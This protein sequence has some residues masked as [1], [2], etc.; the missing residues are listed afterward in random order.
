[1]E[2]FKVHPMLDA[3]SV[4]VMN[5]PL[6]QCRLMNVREYPWL[7]LIPRQPNLRDWIDLSFEDQIQLQREINQ[8]ANV[9]KGQFPCEKLNIAS[10][11]NK[12][13]QLHIHVIAR[14]SQDPAWPNPVW[15]TQ[16]TPYSTTEINEIKER[17]K[18]SVRG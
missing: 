3:D 18:T 13:P 6:S 2:N 7:L 4:F 9:L 16:A 15:N 5:L 17:L 14:T 1:M 11:G 10:L 12:T 8:M